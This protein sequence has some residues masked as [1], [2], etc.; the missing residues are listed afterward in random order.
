MELIP[1]RLKPGL[2]GHFEAAHV[3]IGYPILCGERRNEHVVP[4]VVGV[5]GV[6]GGG[7]SQKSEG[8]CTEDNETAKVGSTSS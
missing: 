4:E 5:G 6:K 7:G 3:P 1:P 2:V 8:S